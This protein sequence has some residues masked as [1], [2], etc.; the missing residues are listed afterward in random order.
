MPVYNERSFVLEILRRVRELP[1]DKEIIIV[2]NCSTDGT[3]ELVRAI[4]DCSREWLFIFYPH[5]DFLQRPDL[6]NFIFYGGVLR[7]LY[8]LAYPQ[9]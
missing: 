8:I 3:R 6:I 7:P 4:I 5:L 2:D 9:I 1:I